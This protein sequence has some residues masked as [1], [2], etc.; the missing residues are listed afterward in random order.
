VFLIFFRQKSITFNTD[1]FDKHGSSA[2]RTTPRTLNEPTASICAVTR[3]ASHI[4]GIEEAVQPRPHGLK[5]EHASFAS[6]SDRSR[7]PHHSAAFSPGHLEALMLDMRG[8]NRRG[9]SKIALRRQ[10][11]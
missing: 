4:H 10:R 1:Q 3:E 7:R 11:K 8:T 5:F 9:G 2:K 6:A